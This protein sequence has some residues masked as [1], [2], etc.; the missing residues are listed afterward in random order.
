MFIKYDKETNYIIG[1]SSQKTDEHKIEVDDNLIPYRSWEP[2]K[3]KYIDN[4]VV[5]EPIVY[6]ANP[7]QIARKNLDDTDWKV[8]RH[9]DQIELGIETSMTDEEYTELLVQ[10]QAWRDT[11]YKKPEEE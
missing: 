7:V 1:I 6:Q 10:R 3:Y 2:N 5:Y 4:E 8:V 9:R 11:D